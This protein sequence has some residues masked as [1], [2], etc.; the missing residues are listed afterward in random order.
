M[1][2]SAAHW[3]RHM[4]ELMT[5]MKVSRREFRGP[6]SGWLRAAV[7]RQRDP[8]KGL[9]AVE[10]AL[11]EVA[12]LVASGAQ[13]QQVC[14]TVAKQVSGL[15]GA[16]V[17]SVVRYD[18]VEQ[19]GVVVGLWTRTRGAVA[20]RQSIDLTGITAT[21][22]V[23][24]TGVSA[25]IRQYSTA[26]SEPIVRSF[27]LTSGICAPII[28]EG[29]LWG[30]VGVGFSPDKRIPRTVESHLASFSALVALAITSAEA[31]ELLSTQ[32]TTDPL[33]GLAN[34]RVFHERLNSEAARSTRHG[35]ALSVALLDLDHFKRINDSFGHQTGDRL[36]AEVGRLLSVAVRSG[37]LVA[38]IGGEEFGWL[39]P[40]A[41]EEFA[42][43]AAERIRYAVRDIL[44]EPGGSI[45]V[46]IGVC[47]TAHAQTPEDLLALA[48][49]ALYL[50]KSGGRDVTCRYTRDEAEPDRRRR[51]ETSS[52]QYEE[53]L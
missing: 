26:S 30:S 20:T 12:T 44:V 51:G 29:R 50:A 37:D 32:A 19:V 17:G 5:W 31:L 16:T 1:R 23:F 2:S 40:E 10:T 9:M 25:T 47:S 36:L 27:A 46:S 53:T 45:T 48:D 22:Q 33:T 43:S 13:V 21:A 6:R 24:R 49:Q 52:G 14:D 15:L 4:V 3:A 18:P 38:R 11:K 41:S 42:Y 7:A 28:V 39:M 8:A 35:R 34:H